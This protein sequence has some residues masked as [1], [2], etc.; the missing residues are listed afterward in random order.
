[1][2]QNS[3]S[4]LLPGCSFKNTPLTASHAREVIAHVARLGEPITRAYI[5][6]VPS[7]LPCEP[8][9]SS[10]RRPTC[11]GLSCAVPYGGAYAYVTTD[12]PALGAGYELDA[13]DYTMRPVPT[14]ERSRYPEPSISTGRNLHNRGQAGRALKGVR[15]H[16]AD[17]CMDLMPPATTDRGDPDVRRV[18]RVN[19]ESVRS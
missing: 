17:T 12:S 10:T 2:R 5:S 6:H 19:G 7:G 18:D 4:M 3:S 11:L 8:P 16:P 13:V 14:L 9:V 15:L 1:M